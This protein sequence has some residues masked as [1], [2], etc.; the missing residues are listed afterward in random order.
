MI[1]IDMVE[2]L[3][4]RLGYSDAEVSLLMKQVNHFDGEAPQR[5]NIV[6]EYLGDY[7]IERVVREIIHSIT[8]YI[9]G[10]KCISI[11]DVGAGSGTLTVK[12]RDG[13]RDLGMD[14]V[15]YGLDISPKMLDELSRKN[16][17][18]IWGVADRIRE[19]IELN[20]ELLG[21]E[22]PDV[23]DVVISTLAL[24]HFNNPSTVLRSIRD[25]LAKD[26]VAI[27]IDIL[28]HDLHMLRDELMD[29]HLGFSIDSIRSIAEE[30]FPIIETEII[31][32]V[33]CRI[34][35]Y[36]VGLFKVVLRDT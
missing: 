22:V 12:I 17:I 7:C 5:D 13:L 9:Q 35:D 28:E 33:Y 18:P 21:V 15:I 34:S 27:I 6:R 4:N 36:K 2:R 14:A 26:G 1:G 23:F 20:S 30:V 32:S 8:V 24:H 10:G 25:V 29:I 16:I 19:C 11:L 3:L 31:D